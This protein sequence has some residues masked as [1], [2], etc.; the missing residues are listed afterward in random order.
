MRPVVIESPFAAADPA[1]N[2]LGSTLS[3]HRTYLARCIADSLGRNEAPLASH[4]FYTQFLD[5]NDPSQRTM[6]FAAGQAWMQ[7]LAASKDP[8]GLVA[9][10]T[11]YGLSSGMKLGISHASRLGLEI[12]FREIGRNANPAAPEEKTGPDI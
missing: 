8:C 9:V 12:E 4:G 3:T 10:Y 6:G 11:D 2:P 7:L 1:T 5:D